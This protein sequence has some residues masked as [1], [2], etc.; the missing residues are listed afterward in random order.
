MTV[1]RVFQIMAADDGALNT[2]RESLF[3]LKTSVQLHFYSFFQLE[4]YLIIS[5]C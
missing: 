3:W 4:L 5:L 2:T 1:L